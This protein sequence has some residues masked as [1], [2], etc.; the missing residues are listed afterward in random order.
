MLLIA[1][2]TPSSRQECR[3]FADAGAGAFEIDVQER[4]GQ[5]VVSHFIPVPGTRGLLQ[6]DNARLRPRGLETG[7]ATLGDVLGILPGDAR[8]LLDPK[9]VELSE[10]RL[11]MRALIE[12]VTDRDRFRVSTHHE[13]DL[14]MLRAS[15]LRT[16]RT[17]KNR[18]QLREV[19]DAGALP[20]EAVS[21][22]ARL[23]DAEVVKRLHDVVESVIAW[24][25][26]DPRRAEKLRGFGVDGLTTDS[27]EVMRAMR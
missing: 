6:H 2:R 14:R 21:V 20:D 25:V 4:Q 19:L 8:I 10:R 12:Q 26:N 3:S 18:R 11:L 9:E 23:L 13:E 1:H 27:R 5:I 16:W 17:V 7:D 22:R 15:G 24:T